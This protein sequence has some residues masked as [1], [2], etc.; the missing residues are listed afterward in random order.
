[1]IEED[2]LVA[3]GDS[4]GIFLNLQR[5]SATNNPRE[6]PIISKISEIIAMTSR[7]EKGSLRIILNEKLG[8]PIGINNNRCIVRK[9]I[10]NIP[11]RK[12]LIRIK[13]FE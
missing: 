6:K 13:P 8:T 4:S 7:M 10:T 12:T 1:M 9:K 11:N 3:T 5:Y 2:V